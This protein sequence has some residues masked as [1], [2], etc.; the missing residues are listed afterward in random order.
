MSVDN[1]NERALPSRSYV[2]A[3][4]E[5]TRRVL[6]YILKYIG[7]PLLAKINRVEGIENIPTTGPAILMINHVSFADS[8]IV[9]N[10]TP[11]N[12]IPM[13][14][15]E[16]YNYPVIGL[17]PKLW[18]V[19]PVRREEVDRRAIQQ[20]LEV[21]RAGEIVLV[22]PEGT[23]GN[24]LKQGKVGVAYMAA[25]T[26][27]PIV[28]VA[29]EGSKDFPAIRF[30]KAWR[31][32]GATIHFGRPFRFKEIYRQAGHDTLRRMTD[33]ALYILAAM[34]PPE[35]RGVYADL[36]QATQETLMI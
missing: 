36:S 8:L 21:L 32:P 14:K 17:F 28:P 30:S 23:R 11:R 6:R 3:S 5:P 7:V 12:I 35:L 13:A 22:A 25:R 29:I 31:Q 26:G 4:K 15:I 19:I 16:V 27:A 1:V 2:H 9:L 20:T 18:G 34:L 10:A 33:E 24:A